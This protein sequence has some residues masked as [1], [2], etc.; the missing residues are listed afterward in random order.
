MAIDVGE[1]GTLS[2]L[3]GVNIIILIGL[4]EF[5]KFVVREGLTKPDG[6]LWG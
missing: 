3:C 5:D 2:A 6:R 1:L 4:R